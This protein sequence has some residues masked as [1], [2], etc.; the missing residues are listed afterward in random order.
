[1]RVAAE[2][3]GQKALCLALQTLITMSVQTGGS[4]PREFQYSGFGGGMVQ[5]HGVENPQNLRRAA[6]H[7]ETDG[8]G[9]A[10]GGKPGAESIAEVTLL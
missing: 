1:V 2:V 3:C 10:F 4:C 7:R 8:I 9:S 5:F 6:R